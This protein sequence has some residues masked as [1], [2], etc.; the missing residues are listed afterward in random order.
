MKKM[1]HEIRQRLE[2][3]ENLVLV[4]VIASSGATPRGAGARMLVGQEGRICGTI[5]GGAVEYRSMKIAQKVLEEQTSRGQDFTLTRDD[6]QNLGMICGG[7]CSVYFHFIAAHDAQAI[8]VARQADRA[9]EEGRD[10]W[11]VEELSE[12]GRLAACGEDG[13][14]PTVGQF[15]RPLGQVPGRLTLEGREYFLEQISS[16]SR[17]YVL[18]CGHVAQEL[19]PVLARVGFRCVVMDDRPE[20]ANRGLFPQAEQVLLVDFERIRDFITVTEKDLV[21]IMTR[22]H[23]Y[24]TVLQAQILRTPAS[25][26][27][28]IGSAHKKAG[29]F[30]RLKEEF[31]CTDQDLER[32]TTPIG[33]SILAQ[34]PA[35][36]AISITGQMIQHRAMMTRK[37]A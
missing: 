24:D 14:V 37:N 32:I 28:V 19:V 20:F 12:N 33:L 21:C 22:G 23:S 15:P 26:I 1:F 17:V 4:T 2:Q 9:M 30:S 35:E 16:S 36:I 29:V 11:L 34:T 8:A 7:N 3:G 25:Y 10:V 13:Q 31:G 6:V 5:G 27:G 18:G